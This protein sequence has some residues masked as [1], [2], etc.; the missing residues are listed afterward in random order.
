MSAEQV[1]GVF[2]GKRGRR[3]RGNLSNA[4]RK[5]KNQEAKMKGVTEG[6]EQGE[7][8]CTPLWSMLSFFIYISDRS[9]ISV[10]D[11]PAVCFWGGMQGS[12]WV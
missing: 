8:V 11:H 2:V 4:E 5:K 6:K 10:T 12:R 3:S 1:H 7:R 9:H